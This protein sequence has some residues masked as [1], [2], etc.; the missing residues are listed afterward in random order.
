MRHRMQTL[1]DPFEPIALASTAPRPAVTQHQGGSAARPPRP[2]E[3]P[4]P[5]AASDKTANDKATSNKVANETAAS[6][7]PQTPAPI[8]RSEASPPGEPSEPLEPYAR[9]RCWCSEEN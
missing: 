9:V 1:V 6:S 2:A 3:K 8:R 7:E 4:L 5:K